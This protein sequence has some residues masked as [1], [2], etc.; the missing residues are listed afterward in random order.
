MMDG[1]RFKKVNSYAY[2][3]GASNVAEN[4]KALLGDGYHVHQILRVKD[5]NINKKP[6]TMRYFVD[7]D[8]N[9][10]FEYADNQAIP[11]AKFYYQ[12]QQLR[13]LRQ[14][15]DSRVIILSDYN[16][17]ALN[18]S[19]RFDQPVYCKVVVVDSR[20]RSLNP[21]ILER[22][23][24]LK[25]WHATGEELNLEW[26][27]EMNFDFIVHTNGADPVVIYES[28]HRFKLLSRSSGGYDAK[29][30]LKVPDTK[31]VNTCGAGDTMVAAIASWYMVHD[32]ERWGERLED[33]VR[34]GIECCQ[35]VIQTPFT[36]VT[37]NKIPNA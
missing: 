25:I 36:A 8:M 29:F 14:L 27:Q 35:E 28:N 6:W 9:V 24:G 1:L 15:H 21:K 11:R 17:G 31:V 2:P 16:K 30:R 13:S 22:I 7:Q 26:A 3:G 12:S 4:C 19:F 23:S 34:F 20:Y 32:V 33:A 5:L 18:G 10:V 37:T